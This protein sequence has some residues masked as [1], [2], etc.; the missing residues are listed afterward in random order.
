MF[1]INL[2]FFTIIL[3][4]LIFIIIGLKTP[5]KEGLRL[6][7]FPYYY[8]RSESLIFYPARTSLKPF[9]LPLKSNPQLKRP[10][11]LLYKRSQLTPIGN[12]GLC[13]SCWAFAI[14]STIADRI[15]IK[16]RGNFRKALS[17]QNLLSCINRQG[18]D[19][20]TLD[21]TCSWIAG[22]QFPLLLESQYPYTM[23][24]GGEITTPCPLDF[25]GLDKI[26]KS[27]EFDKNT[28]FFIKQDSVRSLTDYISEGLYYQKNYEGTLTELEK[29][30][31]EK[32]KKNVE[33]MKQELFQ[34]G[35][36]FCAMS[37]YEDL[38]K[39]NGIGIY[40]Y[41]SGKSVGGHAIE[42]VGYCE[43]GVDDREGYKDG[44]WICRNSWGRN[45]PQHKQ[46]GIGYFIV[47]MGVN[48]CGIE[49]RCGVADPDIKETGEP[50]DW[51]YLRTEYY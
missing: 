43:E 10:R 5:T 28:A 27:E 7:R 46:F 47:K 13:G 34:N 6:F 17:V 23:L 32:C 30:D 37:V 1:L 20:G 44:Y 11:F 36:F 41:T 40:S 15:M 16:T 4:S 29:S 9:K 51:S 31:I 26:N 14:T 3:L 25:L 48:E 2:L 19:G 49:S 21:D 39:Y 24:N 50:I 33:N 22:N 18:C 12:Q 45:W 42:I 35:P 8:K 38:Y